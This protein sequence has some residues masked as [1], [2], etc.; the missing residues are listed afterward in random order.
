MNPLK[1]IYRIAAAQSEKNTKK[2]LLLPAVNYAE[3]Y[4]LNKPIFH[5]KPPPKRNVHL[6]IS[7]VNVEKIFDDNFS[8]IFGF[9]FDQE[10]YSNGVDGK[11]FETVLRDVFQL[12][13][14]QNAILKHFGFSCFV[15]MPDYSNEN[16]MA[17]YEDI[18]SFFV[19]FARE[20]DVEARVEVLDSTTALNVM[21]KRELTRIGLADL[22][23]HWAQ[24]INDG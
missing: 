4:A 15:F 18:D 3:R 14:S 9:I 6:S 5:E 20:S 16:L 19:N 23:Y 7:P 21:I 1:K 10:I 17:A 12:V 22:K 24:L 2:N 8:Q 13:L 11:K